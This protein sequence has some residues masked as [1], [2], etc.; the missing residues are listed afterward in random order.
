MET[1]WWK[2]F[3]N[4]DAVAWRFGSFHPPCFFRYL[5]LYE[6]QNNKFKVI[7]PNT[8]LFHLDAGL[9]WT[10]RRKNFTFHHITFSTRIL[11]K[12]NSSKSDLNSWSTLLETFFLS[13]VRWA[14][15]NQLSQRP[16]GTRLQAT[17]IW[18]QMEH[19]CCGLAFYMTMVCWHH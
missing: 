19:F 18:H 7:P 10:K 9:I 14:F 3:L 5:L 12:V 1:W 4:V 16:R 8:P 15:H 13:F 2:I 6:P 11:I 17:T